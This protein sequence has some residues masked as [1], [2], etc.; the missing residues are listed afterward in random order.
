MRWNGF[1]GKLVSPEIFLPRQLQAPIAATHLPPIIP[2]GLEKYVRAVNYWIPLILLAF[3]CGCGG[4]EYPS[5]TSV[6]GV[7]TYQGQPVADATVVLAPQS[8]DGKAASGVTDA[9]GAFSVSAFADG[10]GAVAGEYKV[11]V[12]KTT[13][14]GA[15][16]PEEEQKILDAGKEVP[17]PKYKE[18]LPP[19][20]KNPATS[21]LTVSVPASG[22]VTLDLDLKD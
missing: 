5:T 16:S 8:A 17:Q 14:I 15:L 6:S 2:T 11:S 20:Y 1:L 21:G 12:S 9:S 18:E 19:K 7:V 4:S 13:V 22:A 3:F 10:E